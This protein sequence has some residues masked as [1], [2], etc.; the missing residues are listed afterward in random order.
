MSLEEERWRG[1]G[2]QE[3]IVAEQDPCVCAMITIWHMEN[4]LHY[5]LSHSPV[6][7]YAAIRSASA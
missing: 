7:S 1:L 4:V 6:S 2:V 5:S 3:A